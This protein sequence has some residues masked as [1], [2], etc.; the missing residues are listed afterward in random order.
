MRVF[1][2][3]R[4]SDS[5]A[6]AGRLFDNLTRALGKDAVFRDI[7]SIAIGTNFEGVLEH[8]LIDADAI[9]VV[10]GPTWATTVDAAGRPRIWDEHDYVRMEIEGALKHDV[11]V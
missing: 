1:I 7:D 5:A 3:Y 10:I 9:I 6:Y 2:N 11:H 4:R 8:S